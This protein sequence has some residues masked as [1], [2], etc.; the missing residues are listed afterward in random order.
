MDTL[1]IAE[2][3]S[4]IA[5]LEAEIPANPNSTKNVRLRKGLEKELAK[6]FKELEDAFPYSRLDEIYSKYAAPD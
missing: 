6:Y 5:L 2:I 1:L 4:L 3:D